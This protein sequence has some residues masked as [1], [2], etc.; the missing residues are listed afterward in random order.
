MQLQWVDADGADAWGSIDR[1]SAEIKF[2]LSVK[3]SA[4]FE[5]QPFTIPT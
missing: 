2:E 4:M 5:I 3:I 1:I